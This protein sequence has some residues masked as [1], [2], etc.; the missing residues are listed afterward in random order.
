MA[1]FRKLFCIG[2]K[3]ESRLRY[4]AGVVYN[5]FPIPKAGYD[6]LINTQRKY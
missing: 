3:L 2:G 5:T 4:S 6:S 1:G